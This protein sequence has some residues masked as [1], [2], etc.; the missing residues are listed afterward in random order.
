M[1]ENKEENP[2]IKLNKESQNDNKNLQDI[3]QNS[4]SK[5]SQDEN[6][7]DLEAHAPEASQ[8]S[9]DS[10]ENSTLKNTQNMNSKSRK[11]NTSGSRSS[12]GRKNTKTDYEKL[13]N[14]VIEYMKKQLKEGETSCKIFV[15]DLKKVCKVSDHI[16]IKKIR[17][18]LI[19]NKII[20][21]DPKDT[22]FINQD[23]KKVKT[24]EDY[25]QINVNDVTENKDQK[26]EESALI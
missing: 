9:Q 21:D 17:P 1:Q 4:D 14:K 13:Y 12:G 15:N 10:R 20:K 25:E 3:E 26:L 18:D 23:Y 16:W 24:I 19:K 2:V 6:P 22:I 7:K 11:K 5:M 8:N